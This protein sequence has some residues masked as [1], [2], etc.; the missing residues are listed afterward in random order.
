MRRESASFPHYK[1]VF[2]S[3][4]RSKSG[5][6][7]YFHL[8]ADIFFAYILNEDDTAYIGTLHPL[9]SHQYSVFANCTKVMYKETSI[10]C[11]FLEHSYKVPSCQFVGLP[12]TRYFEL[13]RNIK[14]S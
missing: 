3:R 9:T 6:N 7:T 10:L 2:P 8:H 5:T 14:P 13:V 12:L 4:I 1:F 11:I